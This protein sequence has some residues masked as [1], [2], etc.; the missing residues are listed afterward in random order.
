MF[1]VALPSNWYDVWSLYFV[2]IILQKHLACLLSITK[3]ISI[4]LNWL[5]NS[6]LERNAKNFVRNHFHSF[7]FVPTQRLFQNPNEFYHELSFETENWNKQ[8]IS[9]DIV[10][11]NYTHTQLQIY[12]VL[13]NRPLYPGPVLLEPTYLFASS[14]LLQQKGCVLERR[15]KFT[16]TN[17]VERSV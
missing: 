1:Q 16:F 17:A 13:F 8:I 2:L 12:P 11:I 14:H 4:S 9:S 10:R 15:L 3:F 5:L 6:A 7:P